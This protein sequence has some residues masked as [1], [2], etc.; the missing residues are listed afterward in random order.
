VTP[1]RLPDAPTPEAVSA[2]A[3]RLAEAHETIKRLNRRVQI[4]EAAANL[5]VGEWNK[6][7]KRAGRAY[8]YQL[9]VDAGRAERVTG[10]ANEAAAKVW[11]QAADM[12]CNNRENGGVLYGVVEEMQRRAAALRQSPPPTETK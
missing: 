2:L 8:V 11:A 1:A 6:R 3:A 10:V 5:K 4:S 12:I 7:S 9:G